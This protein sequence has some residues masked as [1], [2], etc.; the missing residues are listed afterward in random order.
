[1][2]RKRKL[3]I[4]AMCLGGLFVVVFVFLATWNCEIGPYLKYGQCFTKIAKAEE[5][6]MCTMDAKE[7]P[8]GSFVSRVAPDCHWR[9]R[10]RHG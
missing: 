3:K 4:T 8:D 7:C 1:M 10:S 6:T 9:S 2:S 5:L